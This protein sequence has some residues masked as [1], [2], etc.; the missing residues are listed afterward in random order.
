MIVA[1]RRRILSRHT[2][3]RTARRKV[4]A[5]HRA[6][7]APLDAAG[8][9]SRAQSVLDFYGVTR[10]TAIA[11]DRSYR[12]PWGWVVYVPPPQP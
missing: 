4:E 1:P 11:Y 8:T 10:R 12:G 3:R 7:R 9:Y 6:Q 2:L 5:I